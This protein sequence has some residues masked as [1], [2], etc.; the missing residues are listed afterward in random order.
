MGLAPAIRKRATLA[1]GG[2]QEI[3]EGMEILPAG[4]HSTEHESYD[5]KESATG[6]HP[7][8]KTG[9][10]LA[11]SENDAV[12]STK[13]GLLLCHQSGICTLLK[14]F[15]SGQIHAAWISSV[16][17]QTIAAVADRKLGLSSDGGKTAVWRD[18]P[19]AAEQVD[20]LDA[21][22]SADRITLYLFT[23]EG[24]FVSREAGEPWRRIAGGLPAGQVDQWL[25]SGLLAVTERGGG[26]YV[27]EDRGAS[28]NR[29]DG[30]PERSR[31]TGLVATPD[32]AI[33]AGSQNEGLLRLDLR[34][35]PP[36]TDAR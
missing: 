33:L 1:V 2:G 3:V 13:E 15:P 8:L 32:G 31:F 6:T 11:F 25:R 20:G 35:K 34:R 26:F 5:R 7:E 36:K 27:S 4:L 19:V 24:V 12:V 17:G 21:D 9:A 23:K 10:V 30:D 22:Q 18:L 29:V 16:D 28:W 14:A